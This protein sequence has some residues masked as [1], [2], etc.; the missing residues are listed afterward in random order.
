MR[1]SGFGFVKYLNTDEMK[2]YSTEKL[3]E[4]PVKWWKDQFVIFYNQKDNGAQAEPGLR[5]ESEMIVI[6]GNTETSIL[7]AIKRNLHDPELDYAVCA[8]FEVEGKEAIKV[9][10][11]YSPDLPEIRKVE[12]V[13]DHDINKSPDE[14]SS[15][16][17]PVDEIIKKV[18]G[19]VRNYV[20]VCVSGSRT[21][22]TD[23]DVER[24]IADG[25][26]L[27]TAQ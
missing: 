15:E 18:T 17:I 5:Y 3:P 11:E 21:P 19:G 6:D 9:K 1:I 22:E 27:I 23:L 12:I 26:I 16:N 7:E 4:S 2:T 24:L 13:F 14:I 8:N 25:N 10:R 20:V